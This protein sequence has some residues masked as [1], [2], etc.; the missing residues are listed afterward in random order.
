VGP[1]LLLSTLL[2][3]FEQIAR[4]VPTLIAGNP[5]AGSTPLDIA[6]EL[7]KGR[8]LP[9]PS[10]THHSRPAVLPCRALSSSSS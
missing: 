10:S 2:T 5:V 7:L 9:S 6:V 4:P 1:V 3:I 8:A